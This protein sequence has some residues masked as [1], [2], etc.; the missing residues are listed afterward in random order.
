M[1]GIGRASLRRL[2]ALPL[3][4][5]RGGRDRR[6]RRQRRDAFGRRGTAH[7]GVAARRRACAPSSAVDS[8]RVDVSFALTLDGVAQLGGKP[9]T[10][11]VTGPFQRG[12]GR[13]VSAD[14]DRHAHGRAQERDGRASTSPAAP[15]TSAS[16]G[17]STS[18]RVHARARRRPA[19]PPT[20]ARPARA[21]SSRTLG[22]DP[23]RWL[24]DPHVVGTAS[25]G[26]V[27]T[28]HMTA[29]RQRA[30]RA[31]RPLEGARLEV[32]ARPAR[33][34]ASGQSSIV[35]TLLLV[36]SA[37]TSATVDI[38]TGIADHVVRRFHLAIALQGARPPRRARSAA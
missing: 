6:L 1:D 11:D 17:R 26:G 23:R 21:A 7:L 32:P 38:Y 35:S 33:T 15:S 28:N 19:P 3:D 10:V 30:E 5:R 18:C 8:G 31:R 13:S 2:G 12:T 34:G 4:G 22:I 9:I 24:T 16:A 29:Q 27:D 37:I 20:P 14:L 36:Q 25:V